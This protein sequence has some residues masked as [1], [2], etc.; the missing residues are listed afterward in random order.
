MTDAA[1]DGAASRAPGDEA[2][3]AG[4]VVGWLDEL[5][6][7]WVRELG[8]RLQAARPGEVVL[9]L[10]Q[11]ARLSRVGGAVCGQA[12]MAAADTAMVLAL[13]AHHGEFRPLT[14]VNMTTT[15]LRAL[16]A[17]DVRVTARVLRSGRSLAFGEIEMAGAADGKL[18]AH[19]TSTCALL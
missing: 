13:C 1:K 3:L 17:G 16:P 4:K 15:F 5:F 9:V 10:P 19:A 12:L 18:G 7:P 8:L 14:T 6:A 11:D 2:A